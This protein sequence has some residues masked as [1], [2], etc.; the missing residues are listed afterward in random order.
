[1]GI[2]FCLDAKANMRVYDLWR[3]EKIAKLNAC[4]AY[5]MTEGKGKRWIPA[6]SVSNSSTIYTNRG[7]LYII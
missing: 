5:S 2:A 6:N 3:N 1:L 4:S 7:N